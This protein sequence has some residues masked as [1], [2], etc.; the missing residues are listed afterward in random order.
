MKCVARQSL[1]TPMLAA[2]A[3][4][5]ILRKL[6]GWAH[7]PGKREVAMDGVGTTFLCEVAIDLDP[8]GPVALGQSP[9]RNRRISNIVA[10]TFKGARLAGVVRHSGADWS[11]GGIA[12][13]GG[14]AT[15]IDVRSL[16][17]TEDGELIYVTYGGRL[18]VPAAVVDAF[19]D[20]ETVDALDPRAYY[21]HIAPLFETASQR[22]GWLNEI[23]AIGRGRRTATGVV[24]RMFQV[25]R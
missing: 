13:D 18:V 9:W 20:S 12:A 16:W 24:Y 6:S 22:Y 1:R 17:Q 23:V 25:D 14:I 7:M 10:G 8:E 19:R 15:A 5:W 4:P 2:A 11:E 3:D 21:F